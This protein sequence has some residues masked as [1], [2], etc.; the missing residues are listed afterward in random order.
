MFEEILRREE[1]GADPEVRARG[2]VMYY[3]VTC[4]TYMWHVGCECSGA[5]RL[6]HDMFEGILWRGGVGADPAV[7]EDVSCMLFLAWF[8]MYCVGVVAAAA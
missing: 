5:G 3:I 6:K 8:F 2:I 1:V 4:V 7:R